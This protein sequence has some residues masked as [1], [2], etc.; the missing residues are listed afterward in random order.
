MIST[1]RSSNA[2][3]PWLARMAT[4]DRCS[5]QRTIPPGA[6]M[7]NGVQ[8]CKP[9]GLTTGSGREVARHREPRKMRRMGHP[10]LRNASV[11][12]RIAQWTAVPAPPANL[13]I[14]QC[15]LRSVPRVLRN[16]EYS[17]VVAQTNSRL[18][19][20]PPKHTL[21]TASG[22]KS[23]PRSEPSLAWHCTPSP[24]DSHRLP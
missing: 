20:G 10:S 21:E 19:L 7:N 22:I 12:E 3:G 11:G 8:R 14:P 24:A 13:Q 18:S 15:Q 4:I 1:W 9:F 2:G 23:L 16:T 6:P 17:D 5:A